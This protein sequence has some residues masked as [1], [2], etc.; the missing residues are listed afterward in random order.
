MSASPSWANRGKWMVLAVLPV[1]LLSLAP[2]IQFWMQ[3]GSQWHGAYATLNADEFLYAGYL[4]ALIDGRPRRNDPF[5]GRDNGPSQPL[6]ETAFSI[7]VVP[8]FIL[9]TIAR[10]LG[11][12]AST[13]FIV[14]AG[15]AGL[16]ASLAIFWLLSSITGDPRI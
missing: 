10:L 13:T 16:L 5:T 11:L 6:P 3:R 15:V 8:A 9:S 2:Q 14:L 4:N 7:Q 1:L 12:S